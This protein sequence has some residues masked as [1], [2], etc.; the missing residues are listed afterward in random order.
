VKVWRASLVAVLLGGCSYTFDSEG[1]GLPL[2]G[3]P[4]VLDRSSRLNR[5]PAS[6]ESVWFSGPPWV[7]LDESDGYHI[8]DL[9]RPADETVLP[10]DNTQLINGAFY[11]L[12]PD[13]AGPRLTVTPVAGTSSPEIQLRG[14]T[15]VIIGA[16][17]GSAFAYVPAD[18]GGYALS[19]GDGTTLRWLLLSQYIEPAYPQ[20]NG[21]WFFDGSGDWFIEQN[22]DET[23]YARSTR[24]A[25]DVNLGMLSYSMALSS[26]GLA[27]VTCD[28]TGVGL[29]TIADGTRTQVDGTYCAEIV[30]VR[31]N[32]VY[33]NTLTKMQRKSLATADPAVPIFDLSQGR[34]LVISGD[35]V[36]YSTTPV[37]QY[38]NEAGDG[39]LGEW[40]FMERGIGARFSRDGTQLYWLEH[41][42]QLLPVG[43][44]M[45]APIGGPAT[46]LAH[47]VREF[48]ELA[49][50]RLLVAGNQAFGGVQNRVVVIDPVI[51]QATWV[52][53]ASWWYNHIPG[54]TDILVDVV[55]NYEAPDHDVYRVPVPPK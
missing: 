18:Y 48:T 55:G 19:S 52:A 25:P 1:P 14:T 17:R 23:A 26:D 10:D 50:G 47:N 35:R 40:Q 15:G 39:W 4:P 29:V 31:G 54:S 42:A 3:A 46:L 13:P 16:Q 28:Q 53:A 7:V 51:G 38:T 11:K 45:S 49:D 27:L 12:V 36:L 37:D 24:G 30:G 6:D 43:E 21:G 22:I 20:S 5:L 9:S 32:L 34:V 41:A 33:Y 44:L 2:V 8:V